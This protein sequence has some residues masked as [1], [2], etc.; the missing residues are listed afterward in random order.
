LA[1]SAGAAG[2]EAASAGRAAVADDG[3]ASARSSGMQAE[4]DRI[5]L[6]RPP[7]PVTKPRGYHPAEPAPY[8]PP[9]GSEVF[10]RRCRIAYR[11]DT[12]WYLL[13]FLPET[14]GEAKRPV[15]PRWVLPS[16]EL[17][18]VEPQIAPGRGLLCQVSGETTVYKGRAFIL[19][20]NVRVERRVR[21]PAGTAPKTSTPPVRSRPS[22]ESRPAGKA[23]AS[24][25][26]AERPTL[27]DDILSGL[28]ARQPG[29]P[30]FVPADP[31]QV[32]REPSVA[33]KTGLQTIDEDRGQMRIDRLVA[34]M[35]DEAGEWWQARF[36]ADNTLQDQPV[37]LLPCDKLAQAEKIAAAKKHKTAYFRV[38]GVMS[39]YKSREYLLLR[40]VLEER[41]MGQF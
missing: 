12:G 27:A 22:P 10:D 28:L 40:K 7:V 17:E 18:A 32:A 35:P 26:P 37:R 23:V 2:Q 9:D 29:K 6:E 16:P 13:T 33:P 19:L 5:L 24:A 41:Q 8:M 20:R 38:T 1:S 39:R 14:A 30:V 31:G 25:G 4:I 3:Q 36:V 34:I 15:L 11:P 21:K